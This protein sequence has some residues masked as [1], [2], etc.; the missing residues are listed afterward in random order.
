MDHEVGG[1][2]KAKLNDLMKNTAA[3]KE[4]RDLAGILTSLAHKAS[5]ADKDKIAIGRLLD[6]DLLSV[7]MSGESILV[8]GGPGGGKSK[9]AM[10]FIEQAYPAQKW[11][12]HTPAY[13]IRNQHFY[14]KLGYIK[15]AEEYD[16]DFLLFAYEKPMG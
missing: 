14:E 6:G 13:A 1:G 12:L 7:S 5:T 15:M 8:T 11:T 2:D 4:E 3:P 10:Q 9:F 16:D